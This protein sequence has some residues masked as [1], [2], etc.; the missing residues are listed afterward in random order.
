[1]EIKGPHG[2]SFDKAVMHPFIFISRIISKIF[3]T[4]GLSDEDIRGEKADNFS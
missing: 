3:V 4:Q 2:I 1:M